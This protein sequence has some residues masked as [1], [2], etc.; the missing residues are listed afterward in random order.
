MGILYKISLLAVGPIRSSPLGSGRRERRRRPSATTPQPNC[1]STG[2]PSRPRPRPWPGSKPRRAIPS[3]TPC[4]KPSASPR[5]RS[6]KAAPRIK[7]IR[8]T[9]ADAQQEQEADPQD[10]EGEND[11][12]QE[13]QEGEGEQ[14]EPPQPEEPPEPQDGERRRAPRTPRGRRHARRSPTHRSPRGHDEGRSRPHP[15]RARIRRGGD[16]AKGD[17]PPHQPPPRRQNVVGHGVM[18]TFSFSIAC[19]L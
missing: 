19:I 18:R 11:E 9:R 10:A 13:P 6:S 16:H 8:A 17:A 14:G 15:G 7:T 5:H 4:S 12:P 3:S 1:M 2:R